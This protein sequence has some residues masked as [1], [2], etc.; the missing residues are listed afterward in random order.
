[1]SRLLS[2]NTRRLFSYQ[3]KSL[4]KSLQ[5]FTDYPPIK[6]SLMSHT[7]LLGEKI[8]KYLRNENN[9]KFDEASGLFIP[10]Q[11]FDILPLNKQELQ[12][13]AQKEFYGILVHIL[14]KSNADRFMR[15]LKLI[16]F[17][18]LSIACGLGYYN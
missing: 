4:P 3:G 15:L 1:M 5:L 7:P 9:F 14:G 11:Y 17:L 18:L 8:G 6:K 16:I 10:R 13:H 12:Q 2:L